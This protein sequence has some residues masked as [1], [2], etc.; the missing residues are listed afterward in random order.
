MHLAV[1]A[2]T[3]CPCWWATSETLAPCRTTNTLVSGW[4]GKGEQIFAYSKE[5]TDQEAPTC[6][7]TTFAADSGTDPIFACRV[8]WR[9]PWLGQNTA[10]P[11]S[12]R[13][14]QRSCTSS[15]PLSLFELQRRRRLLEI[16]SRRPCHAFGS[17][18][19]RHQG[20]YRRRRVAKPCL[21]RLYRR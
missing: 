21:P 20:H 3:I 8:V 1:W 14:Q 19:M 16:L 7:D 10:R 18:R 9:S 4:I 15:R 17:L 6:R 12:P 2:L 13:T 11:C 5:S